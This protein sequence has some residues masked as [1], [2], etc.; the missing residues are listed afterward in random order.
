MVLPSVERG[1]ARSV[2]SQA[3]I[4]SRTGFDC[5]ARSAASVAS[6]SSGLAR[7]AS[8]SIA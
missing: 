3:R 2:I 6:R 4:S 7:F 8:A 5:F 1:N